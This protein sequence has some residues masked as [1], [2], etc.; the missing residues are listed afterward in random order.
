MYRVKQTLLLYSNSSAH[1]VTLSSAVKSLFHISM[2]DT[3][4]ISA[5]KQSWS[6]LTKQNF[7]KKERK[8]KVPQIVFG[9]ITAS[10][11]TVEPKLTGKCS[12]KCIVCTGGFSLVAP[13]EML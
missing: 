3:G 10:E 1:Y 5:R 9:I 6:S 2:L 8:E 12:L 4:G 13:A 7:I 11:I